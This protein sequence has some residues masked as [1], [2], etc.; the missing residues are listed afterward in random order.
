ME[1]LT[2]ELINSKKTAA[3]LSQELDDKNDF[4]KSLLR[5]YAYIFSPTKVE[6]DG[7]IVNVTIEVNEPASAAAAGV[8]PDGVIQS[9]VSDTT[10][11]TTGTIN[12]EEEQKETD[13]LLK[14]ANELSRQVAADNPDVPGI[15]DGV[16]GGSRKRKLGKKGKYTRKKGTIARKKYN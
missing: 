4:I 10:S 12:T 11:T 5:E 1:K 13:A 6:Q 9:D 16:T 2:E 15:A 14:Q 8:L 3:E 7:N